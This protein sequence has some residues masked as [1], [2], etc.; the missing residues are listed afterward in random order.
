MNKHYICI[1]F[2]A[3]M[4]QLTRLNVVKI[5]ALAVIIS[6]PLQ[7][8]FSLGGWVTFAVVCF[9]LI[10]GFRRFVENIRVFKTLSNTEKICEMIYGGFL[11]VQIDFLIY[12]K[13]PYFIML[14]LLAV[15][16][17]LYSKKA[18]NE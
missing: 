12:H 17:M 5:T 13:S 7:R 6:V 4:I 14:V 3:K 10:M 15:E 8:L 16:Y 11:L 18:R 1:Q 9:Y 2:I